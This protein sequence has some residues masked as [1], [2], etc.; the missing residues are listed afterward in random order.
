MSGVFFLLSKQNVSQVVTAFCA[1]QP[2]HV[3]SYYGNQKKTNGTQEQV[4]LG[5]WKESY[6]TTLYLLWKQG[7]PWKI[8]D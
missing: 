7:K 6:C 8:G 1:E 4:Y 5:G 3:A 2:R